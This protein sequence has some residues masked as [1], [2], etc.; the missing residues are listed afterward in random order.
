MATISYIAKKDFKYDGKLIQ[1]GTE[2]KPGGAR[3]DAQVKEHLVNPIERIVNPRAK[4]R[5]VKRGTSN[6]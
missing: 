6:K 4:K 3:F 2:W 5:T 1:A